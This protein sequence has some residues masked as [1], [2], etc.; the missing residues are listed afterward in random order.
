MRGDAGK[1]VCLPTWPL[2]R[3]V[4]LPSWIHLLHLFS[5]CFPIV[6]TNRK[7][8]YSSDRPASAHSTWSEW[9]SDRCSCRVP[10]LPGYFHSYY[11][12]SQAI[13]TGICMIVSKINEFTEMQILRSSDMFMIVN[14]S[15]TDITSKERKY[16]NFDKNNRKLKNNF[17]N[18]CG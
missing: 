15:L 14:I 1:P 3:F 5:F 2:Y 9:G 18:I 13:N 11:I 6:K 4:A 7:H 8:R 10:Q 12:N 16:G 17:L